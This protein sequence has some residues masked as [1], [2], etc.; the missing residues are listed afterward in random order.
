[1]CVL[2]KMYTHP[3]QGPA[4]WLAKERDWLKSVD[5][6][7]NLAGSGGQVTGFQGQITQLI[8]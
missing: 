1:M 2:V 8:V 6:V 3:M 7:L 4:V 5:Y